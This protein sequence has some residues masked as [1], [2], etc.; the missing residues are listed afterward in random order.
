MAAAIAGEIQDRVAASSKLRSTGLLDVMMS[1][2]SLLL[3]D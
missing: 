3:C 2:C 1:F